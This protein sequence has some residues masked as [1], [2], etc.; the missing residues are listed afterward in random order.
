[1]KKIQASDKANTRK[2]AVKN[3]DDDIQ[4]TSLLSQK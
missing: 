4:E 1:L 2:G 3:H